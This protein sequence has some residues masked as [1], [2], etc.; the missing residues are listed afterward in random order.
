MK[1]TAAVPAAT[2]RKV[3]VAALAGSM[4]E[5]YDFLLFPALVV[6]FSEQFFPPGNPTANL[7]AGLVTYSVSY[8]VRP[9]GAFVFGHFGDRA[10]R[11]NTFLVSIT[12]MGGA[13]AAIG[14]LPTFAQIGW[15]APAMLVALRLTQGLSMAGEY[16]GAATYVAE[17][18]SDGRRGYQTSW[19]QIAV[20]LGVA[21]SGATILITRLSMTQPQFMS[22]G[23]RLPFLLSIVILAISIYIRYGLEESPVFREM[24][25]AHQGSR[26]PVAETF[27]SLRNLRYVA[28]AFMMCSGQ[29]VVGFM[30]TYSLI[31]LLAVLKVGYATTYSLILVSQVIAFPMA[32]A[33]GWLSDFVGR[34]WIM[35]GGCLLGALT[36]FP[37]FAALTRAANPALADFQARVPVTIAADSCHLHFLVTAATKLSACDRARDFLTSKGISYRSLPGTAE[38]TIVTIGTR[39]LHGF[40]ATQYMAALRAQGYPP[41]ADPHRI[42]KLKV[43]LILVAIILY[44]TMTFGPLGAFLTEQFPTRIRFSAVSIA[45]NFGAGWVGGLTPFF[46]SILSVRAGDI[47]FGLW[48][49]VIACSLVFVLGALL[50]EEGHNRAIREV[51][52]VEEPSLQARVRL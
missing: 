10:G 47:F 26:A 20:F 52:T 11:K 13:T 35:L 44:A 50:I 6:F 22:W 31:F 28:I 29:V 40:D 7:L 39:K 43:E 37:L 48:F 14:L 36:Y 18:A 23:W 46:I 2:L 15:M 32:I 42:D 33:S 3:I 51:W 16:S 45:Y 41:G 19:V 8:V 34:K 30:T 4:F 21:L 24:R 9:L 49:P 38:G 12:M 25:Q 27:G 5:W 1:P 17:H